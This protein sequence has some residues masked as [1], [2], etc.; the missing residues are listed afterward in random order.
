[1]KYI[2]HD[3]YTQMIPENEEDIAFLYRHYPDLMPAESVC[4]ADE[5]SGR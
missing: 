5:S 3:T 1:M 4:V 2:K